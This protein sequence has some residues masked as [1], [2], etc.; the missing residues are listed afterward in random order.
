AGHQPEV[1]R[2][3]GQPAAAGRYLL[4]QPGLQALGVDVGLTR[5]PERICWM[6]SLNRVVAIA[7][8]CGC[9]RRNALAKFTAC[10]GSTL[11]GIGGSLASRATSTSAGPSCAKASRS[12]GSRSPGLST[13]TPYAP[14]P[15][16]Q[17]A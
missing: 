16:A 4:P 3:T 5:Y 9:P 13:A 17:A 6:R 15:R 11:P 7:A 1:G 8:R 2:G 10:W 12:A 14:Q